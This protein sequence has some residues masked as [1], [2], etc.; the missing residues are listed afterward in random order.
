ME[1]SACIKTRRSIRKFL[2]KNVED[3]KI[4]EI[5]EA[6]RWAPSAGNTNEIRF[7]IVKDLEIRKKIAEACL[8]QYWMTM[9]PVY[10][11]VLSKYDKVERLYGTRGI[12]LYMPVGVGA[13]IQNLLLRATDL[14]LGACWVSAFDDFLVSQAI[15][16]AEDAKPVAVIPV[17]YP[18]SIP[19]PPVKPDLKEMVFFEK[20]GQKMK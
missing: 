1:A 9:A 4:L 5:L 10:I 2:P 16:S 3:E 15:K 17:G 7:V 6:A 20:Y 19:T 8:G 12:N 13:A 14:G 18:H 11:V